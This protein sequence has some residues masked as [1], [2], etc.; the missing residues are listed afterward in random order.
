MDNLHPVHQHQDGFFN[1]VSGRKI[2]L[3][4]PTGQ[5]INISDIAHGLAHICR[6]GGHT[7]HYYSVAQHSILVMKLAP[8]HLK[9]AALMHDA[10]EAYLGDVIK[11]LKNI[12]GTAYTDIEHKFETLICERFGVSQEDVKAI[13]PYDKEAIEIEHEYFFKGRMHAFTREFGP[14]YFWRPEE[15]CRN[16]IHWFYNLNTYDNITPFGDLRKEAH[17][18]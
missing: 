2:D 15:A 11:P 4:N 17:H 6:F 9:F 8:Q 5:M 14:M 18:G 16:F 13:K 12:I 10:P 3:N 1:T 7:Q